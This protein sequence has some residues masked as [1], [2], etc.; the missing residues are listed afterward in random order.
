[1]KRTNHGPQS[2][3]GL[4]LLSAL[5]IIAALTCSYPPTK[6]VVP[7]PDPMLPTATRVSSVETITPSQVPGEATATPVLPDSGWSLVAPGLEKR[8][9]RIL[10]QAGRPVETILL[11]RIESAQ[12]HF[13]VHYEPGAPRTV[14]QWA[15]NTESLITL[16]AGYFTPEYQ[17][18]GLLITN[19]V[20]YGTSYGDFAGMLAVKQESVEV[21]WLTEQPFDPAELLVAAVQSFPVLIQPGGVPG[22]P[23]EDGVPARRTV[24]GQDSAGRIVII[25]CPNGT[26][27]LHQL[28]NYLLQSDLELDIALNLDGGTSTGLVLSLAQ[29]SINIPSY[30]P[31]PSVITINPRP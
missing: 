20:S 23:E 11:L 27:T 17:T 6:P 9:R 10:D 13:E 26:L 21:R 25:I 8:T 2:R 16:N 18:T 4:L 7:A 31:V 14:Q 29:E 22:F 24:V 1:M 3:P 12:Y 5:L 19:G 28:A 15:T 30:I